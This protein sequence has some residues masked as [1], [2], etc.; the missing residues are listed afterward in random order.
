MAALKKERSHACHEGV[1]RGHVTVSLQEQDAQEEDSYLNTLNKA[2]IDEDTGLLGHLLFTYM[3]D[4]VQVGSERVLQPSDMGG[5]STNDDT[6][7]CY[8]R[9]VEDWTRQ[10]N[11]FG[12]DAWLFLALLRVGPQLY[13]WASMGLALS[14]GT[15]LGSMMAL[16]A[17]VMHLEGRAVQSQVP[18]PHRPSLPGTAQCR[19]SQ[20]SLPPPEPPPPPSFSHSLPP[21]L[22]GRDS[23]SS[24]VASCSFSRS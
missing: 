15:Q 3:S 5:T 1:D 7:D 12:D 20:Q 9:F 6:E 23:S 18:T 24:S 17:V 2:P 11:E 22:C 14:L 21:S 19:P 13:L 4:L 8:T 10:R 16:R